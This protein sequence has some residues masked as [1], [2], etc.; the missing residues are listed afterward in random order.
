MSQY[1]LVYFGI[2][3]TAA[4]YLKVI[5]RM[6]GNADT[7]AGHESAAQK[8]FSTTVSPGNSGEF[9]EKA[10][11][12]PGFFEIQ[13]DQQGINLITTIYLNQKPAFLQPFFLVPGNSRRGYPGPAQQFKKASGNCKLIGGD[14]EDMGF[15]ADSIITVPE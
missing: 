7:A 5:A 12:S 6:P 14:T 13:V 11:M 8:C 10:E 9:P 2:F 3:K 1:I 4:V 15:L